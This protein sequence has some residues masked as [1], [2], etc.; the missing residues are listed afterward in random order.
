MSSKLSK[1]KEQV[2]K[3]AHKEELVLYTTLLGT[4]I[5][6]IGM[7]NG[8]D[9]KSLKDYFK[10]CVEH[11]NDLPNTIFGICNYVWRSLG[12]SEN[13][14]LRANMVLLTDTENVRSPMVT[15]VDSECVPMPLDPKG[16]AYGII[17]CAREL[18]DNVN[19]EYLYNEDGEEYVDSLSK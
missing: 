16:L 10:S 13:I 18:R 15:I 2:E 8:V 3:N 17:G 12:K 19:L 9:I 6:T 14:P 5:S 4:I 7:L 1:I 11:Y